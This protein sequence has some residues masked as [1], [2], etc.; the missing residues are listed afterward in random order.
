MITQ[1]EA[2]QRDYNDITDSMVYIATSSNGS[3]SMDW[4][5]GQPIRLRLRYYDEFKKMEKE[6]ESGSK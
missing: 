2:R 4:L 6:A 1:M 3:I 5:M